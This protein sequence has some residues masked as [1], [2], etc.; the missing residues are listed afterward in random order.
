MKEALVLCQSHQT[1]V[2]KHHRKSVFE[3][4]YFNNLICNMSN[5]EPKPL[6]VRKGNPNSTLKNALSSSELFA[7]GS[8]MRGVCFRIFCSSHLW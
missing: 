4:A 6:F 5:P 7:E 2:L 8:G 1:S 3:A